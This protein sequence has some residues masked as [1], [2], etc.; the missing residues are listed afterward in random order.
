MTTLFKVS[1]ADY[2]QLEKR[3]NYVFRQP[4][5]L[6]QALTHRSHSQPHNERLE[7][8]G[9][10]VLNCV[11]A[12]ILYEKF[13]NQT[14]GDL[15]RIRA[16]LVQQQT[17]FEISQSLMLG[18]FLRLGEGE[19]RSGGL[20]RPSILADTLEA[21]LGAIFLDSG[22]TAV[23][24]LLRQLYAPLL[25][26]LSAQHFGKDA[27]T[28]LQELLQAQKIPIPTYTVIAVRGAAHA[29]D[30]QVECSIPQLQFTVSGTGGSRRAAEQV[31]AK[32]ALQ[33]LTANAGKP[34]AKLNL[35]TTARKREATTVKQANRKPKSKSALDHSTTQP[36]KAETAS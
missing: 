12:Q 33:R 9:D 36:N 3:L 29:Q 4:V 32:L 8:L 2:A 21:I 22:F 5:L 25:D 28:Q 6:R 19:L 14:E 24:V 18:D 23:D 27:K 17:L 10:S 7:F 16:N 20:Q 11:I 34:R 35:S 15:S 30:F 13:I 1:K 26:N 31:A